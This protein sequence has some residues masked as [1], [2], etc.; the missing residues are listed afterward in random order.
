MRQVW[1]TRRGGPEV[2]EIREVPD[3]R[4]G[5]G[6]VRVRVRAAGVNFADVMIRVGVYSNPPRLPAVVGYE[7]AGIV[8]AVG[9]DVDPKLQDSPALA[10]LPHYGGYSESVVIPAHDAVPI[11]SGI[12]FEQAAGIPVNYLT[13]WLMLI[14]L[15][16]LQSGERVLI[17]GAGG[18]VGLAALQICRW[19][20]AEVFATASAWKHDRLREV[21]AAHCIDYRREDFEQAARDLTGGRGMDVILDPIGGRSWKKSARCLAPLGRLFLLGVSSMIPSRRLNLWAVVK[22]LVNTP[23]F[24]PLGLINRNQGVFGISL[25]ELG[26]KAALLGDMLQTVVDLTQERHF[27]PIVDRTFPLA[28]AGRAHE[29]LQQRKNFGKVVLAP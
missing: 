20:G 27:E 3:I 4:P 18:G 2:L 17:H 15:G 1:I 6:Q 29:Y 8:D 11:P 26:A 16:N 28:E 9:D 21:G 14:R 22:G 5:P 23:R 25:G 7:V 13:A 19:R 24:H 10:L 12:S